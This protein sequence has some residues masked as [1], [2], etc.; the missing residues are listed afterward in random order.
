MFQLWN[1]EGLMKKLRWLKSYQGSI[2]GKEF[3][4]SSKSASNFVSQGFAEYAEEPNVKEEKSS[5]KKIIKKS[6]NVKENIA[7]P[8]LPST[9]FYTN[10][11]TTAL[12]N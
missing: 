4:A 2:V 12:V 7:T 1:M 11:P 10:S 5:K 8:I 6:V 3:N 9:P